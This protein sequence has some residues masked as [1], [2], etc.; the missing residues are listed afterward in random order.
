MLLGEPI[1]DY[2]KSPSINQQHVSHSSQSEAPTQRAIHNAWDKFFNS[3]LAFKDCYLIVLLV[4]CSIEAL[5]LL[6]IHQNP[7]CIL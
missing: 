5:L 7:R 6:A 3:Q 4:Y 1:M 2:K